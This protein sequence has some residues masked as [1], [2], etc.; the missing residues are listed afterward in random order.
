[1]EIRESVTCRGHA[2]VSGTH[3][4]TFEITAEPFCTPAGSCILGVAANTG[5]AGLPDAFKELLARDDARLVT[6]FS[7]GTETFTV[8]AQ[9]SGRM[10]LDHPTDL[11]WRRS[12]FVCGRTVGI[13]ADQTALSFPRRIIRLLQEG[14]A[15]QVEMAVAIPA[16]GGK[17]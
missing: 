3:K 2:N 11:V 4:T 14:A 15:M 16:Q 5:A 10:T 12:S 7:V 9:G 17:S 13:C 8:T 6:R 1:M